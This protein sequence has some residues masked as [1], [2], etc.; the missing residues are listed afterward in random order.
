LTA[1][2]FNDKAE[3]SKTVSF[4]RSEGKGTPS[5]ITSDAVS[6]FFKNDDDTNCPMV[7]CELINDANGQCNS[8]Y[9]GTRLGLKQDPTTKKWSITANNKFAEG[10]EEKVCVKCSSAFASKT[11]TGL[12]VKQ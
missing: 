1:L 3:T 9:S 12:M 2:T 5:I 8:P 7:K 6:S 10:Y 4:D 11:F